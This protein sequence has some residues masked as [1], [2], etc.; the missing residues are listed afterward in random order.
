VCALTGRIVCIG[1]LIDDG[2]QLEEP[3]I[4]D[5][6]EVHILTKFWTRSA[7]RFSRSPYAHKKVQ[8]SRATL[9]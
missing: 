2:A 5:E 3:A 4:T 1:M 6:N 9:T 8:P 7:P